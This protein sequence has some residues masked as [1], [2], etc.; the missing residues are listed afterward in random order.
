MGSENPDPLV[1]RNFVEDREALRPSCKRSAQGDDVRVLDDPKI[2]LRNTGGRE[3][4][5]V[6]IWLSICVPA[7][8]LVGITFLIISLIWMNIIQKKMRSKTTHPA[9]WVSFMSL[10]LHLAPAVT[11]EIRPSQ[12]ELVFQPSIFRCYVTFREGR[13]LALKAFPLT[14]NL[15]STVH[16]SRQLP[17][18][19]CNSAVP[20]MS[21]A[22]S[23]LTLTALTEIV[24]NSHSE[25]FSLEFLYLLYVP[26]T[27]P[28]KIGGL[29]S[30]QGP[31]SGD[32]PT[33]TKGT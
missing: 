6:F 2:F 4:G 10:L 26:L 21:F 25:F 28:Q 14:L 15:S 16:A 5:Y 9:K 32:L 23:C 11:P 17:R 20:V 1:L 27:H 8:S 12:K 33:K 3:V 31:V 22:C 30:F 18:K 19:L 24:E 29:V 7:P 13:C